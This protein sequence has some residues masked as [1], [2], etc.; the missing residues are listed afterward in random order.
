MKK[1][2]LN[3][4][5]VAVIMLS[6]ALTS[7][8][9]EIL[10]DGEPFDGADAGGADAD[11]ADADMD[12]FF[13]DEGKCVYIP[14]Y[15]FPDGGGWTDVKL[16][17]NGVTEP[18]NGISYVTSVYVS[19]DDVYVAGFGIW[20]AALWKNGETQILGSYQSFANSVYVSDGNVYVAGNEYQ[21][22]NTGTIQRSGSS[23]LDQNFII[24]YQ[25]SKNTNAYARSSSEEIQYVGVAKLWKNGE[26]QDITDGTYDATANSVFLAGD[27]VYVAGRENNEQGISVVKL[28]KNGVA[29]NLT[30]GTMDGRANSVYVSDNDVYVAGTERNAQGWEVAKLWKN[31]EVQSLTND[32]YNNTSAE[33]HSVY[34]SGEDVYVVGYVWNESGITHNVA[35]VWKNG[36]VYNL[37][38]GSKHGYAYSVFVK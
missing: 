17:K 21:T 24:R 36:A 27:D 14:T 2:V 9:N 20:Y 18:I 12:E 29:Q 37:T 28:W 38:D 25:L 13:S 7:C 26:A 22:K 19:G 4:L 32:N 35:K 1:V 6:A 23:H 30:D 16:W 3:Y 8:S 10:Y 34:V 15:E 5:V 33:A 31:G 11:E